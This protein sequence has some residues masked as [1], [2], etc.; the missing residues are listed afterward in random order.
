MSHVKNLH[1]VW[2]SGLVIVLG[3]AQLLAF[4]L[5]SRPAEEWIERLERPERI[6]SLKAGEVVSLLKLEAG[7]IVA[8]I[9]AGGGVFSRALAPAVAPTGKVFAVEIDQGFLDYINQR[10]K[11][12]NIKNIQTVLGEFDDPKLP[13]REVD[14]AFIHQVLHHIEH[15]QVYLKALASYL[16]PDGRIVVIDRI[17][18]HQDDPEM[19]LTLEDVKQ[20]MAT[21]GFHLAEEFG[22]FEDKFFTVFS[23]NQ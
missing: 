11:E 14:L 16:K 17:G 21:A 2:L 15:R 12:E 22:L 10:A 5:G 13:T 23:R 3:L 9:G 8:D 18:G 1:R 4:Q 6:A 19:Q 20:L 7:N